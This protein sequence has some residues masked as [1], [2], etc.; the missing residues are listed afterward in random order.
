MYV[1]PI[2]VAMTEM[3]ENFN[4][5]VLYAALEGNVIVIKNQMMGTEKKYTYKSVEGVLIWVCEV[6]VD[7]NKE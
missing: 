2:N 4:H 3:V 6:L 5:A 7:E 1:C